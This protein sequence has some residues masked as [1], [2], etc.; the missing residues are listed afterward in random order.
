MS[1]L[2]DGDAAASAAPPAASTGSVIVAAAAL[3]SAGL[4]VGAG[5]GGALVGCVP[6]G[7]G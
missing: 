2:A 4:D 6:D 7:D 5:T 1:V 3:V